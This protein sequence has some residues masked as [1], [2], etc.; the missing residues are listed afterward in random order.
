MNEPWSIPRASLGSISS[1]TSQ[2]THSNPSSVKIHNYNKSR[3]HTNRGYLSEGSDLE[4]DYRNKTRQ[5]SKTLIELR[6][7]FDEYSNI[8]RNRV[9]SNNGDIIGLKRG[10][11][12]SQGSTDSNHSSHVSIEGCAFSLLL[13][14]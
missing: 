2:K 3:G 6:H 7:K 13:S 1:N 10:S 9:I 4:Q 5:P 14:N 8:R 12:S 11:R